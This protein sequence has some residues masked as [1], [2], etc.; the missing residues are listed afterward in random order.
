M[1]N[2]IQTIVALVT[3]FG[4]LFVA[5]SINAQ[6][7]IVKKRNIQHKEVFEKGFPKTLSF[8]DEFIGEDKGYNF[9][10]TLHQPFNSIT[11]KYLN[12]EKNVPPLF[13]GWANKYAVRNPEK[14]MLL[15]LNGEGRSVNDENMHKLYFPGHWVYEEGTFLKD[16]INMFQKTISLQNAKYFSE[17]AYTKNGQFADGNKL[18]HDLIIVELDANGNRLWYQCEFATI[19]SVDYDKNEITIKR[20]Q[21]KTISKNFSKKNTYVAPLAADFW[22]GN[23]MW[24]YNLSTSCPRDKNGNSA[25]D[26]FLNEIKSWFGTGG[27]LEEFDGIGFDVNYF[28]TDH[29]NWDCNNDGK[30]ERGIIDGKNIWRLGDIEFLRGIR[31]ALGDEFL[32]TA[33]GWRDEMQRAVGILNGMETEGLCRPGDGYRQI[34]R[35]INQ[36]TYWNMHNNTKYKF[37]YITSKLQNPD[38][39]KIAEQLHRMGIGIASCFEVAYAYPPDMYIS[40][41]FGGDLIQSNWLGM[42]AGKIKYLHEVTNDLFEGAGLNFDNNFLKKFDFNGKDF[43][44]KKGSLFVKGKNIDRYEKLILPGPELTIPEGDLIITFEAKAIQG[45][46]DLGDKNLIPRKINI[47][48]EGLPEFPPE[49]LNSQR[50]YNDLAGFMGTGGFTPQIFYFRNA[51]NVSNPLKLV[52]EADEQGEFVIRNLKV[53]NAPFAFAREFDKGLVLVNPSL[54][55]VIFDLD[56]IIKKDTKFRRLKTVI[57]EKS[58]LTVSLEESA[59]Y[60]DGSEVVNN[61]QVHVTSLNALFLF[62]SKSSVK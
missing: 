26:V 45:F 27:L 24:Y 61:S 58:P 8:R 56:K 52:F 7:L 19:E 23:L 42:P 10:E 29:E 41:A 28:E 17:K 39:K 12:E 30:A 55:S 20:G 15:H 60:N 31:Q 18:P 14:L 44:V 3:I 62:K 38:D 40:E 59:S 32:I 2:K 54:Q 9:W 48:I 4:Y 13:A 50:L 47:R 43:K 46:Y 25:A 5:D 1:K 57:P 16:D 49:P 33:D 22:G 11:K 37:S 51:G 53:F 6:Q 34:S 35:T 21:Y 36:H